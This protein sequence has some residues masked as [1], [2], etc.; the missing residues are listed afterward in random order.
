VKVIESQSIPT[1]SR[2][3][4][5]PVSFFNPWGNWRQWDDEF[6]KFLEY[7][8]VPRRNRGRPGR[9][10]QSQIQ[11]E[12]CDCCGT[13]CQGDCSCGSDS[14]HCKECSCESCC[15]DSRGSGKRSFKGRSGKKEE[16]ECKCT[17]DNCACGSNCS[18]GSTCACGTCGGSIRRSGKSLKKSESNQLG[19]FLGR[20]WGGFGDFEVKETDSGL[21][22][23]ST[24]PGF[25]KEDLNIELKDNVLFVRG[26]QKDEKND[27]SSGSYSM[28]SRSVV[29]SYRLPESAKPEEIKATFKDDKLLIDIPVP[30]KVSSGGERKRLTIN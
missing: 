27:E 25:E 9:E 15:G 13:D 12:V 16:S 23:S 14:G 22:L 11:S 20:G 2:S 18:C 3:V 28:S 19:N 30:N 8:L 17:Q 6:D 4:R 7:D 26:E 24:W 1:M 29:R 10:R 21:N 5:I